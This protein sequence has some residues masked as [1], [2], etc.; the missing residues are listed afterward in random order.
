MNMTT[1]EIN[2]SSIVDF[3]YQMSIKP[4]RKMNGYYMY[5]SP[6]RPA[7]RTPSFKVSVVSNLWVD[8]GINEGGTLIDLILKINP[9]YTVSRIVADFNKGIFSFHQLKNNDKLPIASKIKIIKT[10]PLGS[11]PRACTY[12]KSRGIEFNKA[13]NYVS[14]ISYEINGVV[15]YGIATKNINGG[16]NISS[17]NFKCATKQG[18]T[19]YSHN[20]GMSI[21]VTEGIM[22]LLS[23]IMLYPQQV[24]LHD[25]CVLNSVHN[26]P[27]IYH[28]LKN[29]RR[30]ICFLDNDLAGDKTT[31]LIK[32]YSK[33]NGISFFDYRERYR[34]YK[35]LND[36]LTGI[37][38]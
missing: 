16:Y 4:E 32:N 25:F 14:G 27:G 38:M 24:G 19:F 5:Y 7:E 20:N 9:D 1:R 34:E 30:I 8:F 10:E 29:N 37:A 26:L 11:C 36:Y 31:I 12:L 35:D 2:K 17:Q 18:V 3:L 21:I 22:D 23:F 28:I 6:I 13:C 33:A 15:Y